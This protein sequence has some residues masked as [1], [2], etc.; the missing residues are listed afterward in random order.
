MLQASGLEVH[1]RVSAAL[2]LDFVT[3]LLA[4]VEAVKTCSLDGTDVDE[5]ILPTAI[6]LMKPNPLVKL[7]HL[8]VPDAMVCILV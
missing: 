6:R 5:N 3:D 8:T 4:L 1:R 7:N 2:G